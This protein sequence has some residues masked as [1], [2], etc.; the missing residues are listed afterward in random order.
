M[1]VQVVRFRLAELQVTRRLAADQYR[2]NICAQ[3]CSSED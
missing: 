3:G 1:I 2:A